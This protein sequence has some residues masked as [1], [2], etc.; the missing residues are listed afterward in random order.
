MSD[1]FYRSGDRICGPVSR[2]E[3]DFLAATGRVRPAT[4][5]RSGLKGKWNPYRSKT[6]V[7]AAT[8]PHITPSVNDSNSGPDTTDSS[9]AD[10][11]TDS[12]LISADPVAE[13]IEEDPS[14]K[15]VVTGIIL[16]TGAL[17]ALLLLALL[18]PWNTMPDGPWL[19]G[20]KN[21]TSA[22]EEPNATETSAPEDQDELNTDAGTGNDAV[23][24][25][26]A[27][28]KYTISAP[29]EH[30]DFSGRVQ[31]EG[32]K[33]GVVQI[34]LAWDDYND[35]DLHL[36]CPSGEHIWFKNVRSQCGG[37]LD[38]DM[39]VRPSS[40]K[41]PV[42]NIVWVNHAPAGVYKI[43][44]HFYKQHSRRHSNFRVRVV[45]DGQVRIYSGELTSGDPPSILTSFT[46]NDTD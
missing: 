9:V 32:G 35:L 28:S 11:P 27:L 37:E 42:E 10:L 7:S 26:D 46:L 8:S 25:G 43:L 39:N 20:T 1:W 5:V 22:D 4:E 23:I 13:E 31:R 3:L 38:V 41:Q 16:G 45:T 19:A 24:P 14:K 44:V 29:G 40:S 36:L 34:S 2:E 30:L 18:L 21:E 15:Y 17:L 33:S 6:R 12:H